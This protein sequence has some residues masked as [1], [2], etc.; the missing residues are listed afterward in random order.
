VIDDDDEDTPSR[1][2]H[3]EVS[4]EMLEGD[5]DRP[6]DTLHHRM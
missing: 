5:T 3:A 1:I 2:F 6:S 4:E